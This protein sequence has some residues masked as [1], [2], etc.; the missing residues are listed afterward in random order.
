ML[1]RPAGGSYLEKKKSETKTSVDILHI[2]VFHQIYVSMLILCATSL[3]KQVLLSLL[4]TLCVSHA[5]PL[6]FY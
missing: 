6:F 3:W 5:F 1:E 2:F 4:P